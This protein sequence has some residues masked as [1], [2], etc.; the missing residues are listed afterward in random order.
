MGDFQDGADFDFNIDVGD[1]EQ[2]VQDALIK[3]GECPKADVLSQNDLRRE[4]NDRGIQSKGFFNDDAR[5]L[6]QEFD[7]EHKETL[8]N[9]EQEARDGA[10]RSARQKAITCKRKEQE[11]ELQ[12]EQEALA[13]DEKISFWLELMKS[14]HTPSSA[15][16]VVNDTTCR[17]L[18]FSSPSIYH[19]LVPTTP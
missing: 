12:D 13:K 16:L 18:K 3:L 19:C 2:K 14:N 8:I 9:V 15:V 4:L 5:R 10:A 7:K 6:Q 11:R 1:I 17:L